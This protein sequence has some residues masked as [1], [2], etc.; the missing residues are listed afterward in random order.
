MK[1]PYNP[2]LGYYPTRGVLPRLGHVMLKFHVTPSTADDKT[3][4]WKLCDCLNIIHQVFF[5][6]WFQI[7]SGGASSLLS[8]LSC[9]LLFSFCGWLSSSSYPSHSISSVTR[10][11]KQILSWFQL[12]GPA[13]VACFCMAGEFL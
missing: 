7:I 8:W 11:G 9:I 4:Q 6:T 2:C 1:L 13:V 12:V 3:R 5:L 10:Y